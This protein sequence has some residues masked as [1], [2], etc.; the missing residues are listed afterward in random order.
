M[1]AG[2]YHVI[3][4]GGPSGRQTAAEHPAMRQTA[5]HPVAGNGRTHA[6][7]GNTTKEVRDGKAKA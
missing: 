7:Q 6:P 5:G 2:A 1:T 3:E 4:T